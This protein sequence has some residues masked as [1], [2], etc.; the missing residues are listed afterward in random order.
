MTHHC[1]ITCPQGEILV[2]E[3][4]TTRELSNLATSHGL[5]HEFLAAFIAKSSMGT[6]AGRC[7]TVMIWH[8]A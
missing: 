5:K 4:A 1:I 2:D 3:R 6:V 8:E 7:G